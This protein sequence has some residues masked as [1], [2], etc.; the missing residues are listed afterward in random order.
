MRVETALEMELSQ[1]DKASI[2]QL[3]VAKQA[4]NAFNP[5]QSL[6]NE[7]SLGIFLKTSSKDKTEHYMNYVPISDRVDLLLKPSN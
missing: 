3:F 1:W 6:K 2:V 7:V 5:S 4:S